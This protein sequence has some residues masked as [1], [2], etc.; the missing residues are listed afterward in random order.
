MAKINSKVLDNKP[1]PRLSEM[2]SSNQCTFVKKRCI[3]D[4]FVL[5]QSLIMEFHMKKS[6]ALFV[7]LDI[8]KTFD[9]VSWAYLLE[10]LQR[11]GFG[12]NWRN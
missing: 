12:T 7:N 6:S 4:N 3:H 2:V 11:L 10:V 8:A 9:S 5:F 1:A